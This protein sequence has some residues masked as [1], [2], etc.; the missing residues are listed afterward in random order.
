MLTDH[1]HTPVRVLFLCTHNSARSQMA[2]A[3]LRYYGGERF[4]SY[5]AG[6]EP[7]EQIH[8]LTVAVMREV[9]IPLAGQYPKN[10]A[11][12]HRLGLDWDYIIT[13]CDRANDTC[14]TFPDDTARIHWGFDDPAACRGTAEERQ[15][16]F[17]RIRDEVKRRVQL[18]AEL[19]VH[20]APRATQATTEAKL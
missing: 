16:C 13:T 2:E 15:R 7:A 9:N 3:F 1:Y 5:S 8:P 19:R 4:V 10:L 6:T 20:R 11:E 17:R 14:P 18:F 12:V